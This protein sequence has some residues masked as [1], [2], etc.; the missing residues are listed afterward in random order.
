[1]PQPAQRFVATTASC[2]SGLAFG[3]GTKVV[4]AYGQS[5]TQRRQPL[6]LSGSTTA[7]GSAVRERNGN[8]S[9]TSS[10]ATINTSTSRGEVA[11]ARGSKCSAIQSNA[12]ALGTTARS[13]GA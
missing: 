8:S 10:T 5:S 7:T 9:N 4:A 2:I 3:C 12:S 13:A 6:Q 11:S 1:M